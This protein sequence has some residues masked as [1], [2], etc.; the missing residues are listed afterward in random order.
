MP[1]SLS[2]AVTAARLLLQT[3]HL[4]DLETYVTRALEIGPKRKEV[5]V[6]AG[7]Y[8]RAKGSYKKALSHIER[9]AALD[10]ED[11]HVKKLLSNLRKRA[12]SG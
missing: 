5:L 9:A 10:G 8:H 11:G 3:G 2:Y 4:D 6:L 1:Q 7:E 12:G